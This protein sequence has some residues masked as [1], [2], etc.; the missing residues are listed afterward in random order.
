MVRKC[1]KKGI[2]RPLCFFSLNKI[3]LFSYFQT[4]PLFYYVQIYDII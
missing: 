3:Y 2:S 4:S 1:N